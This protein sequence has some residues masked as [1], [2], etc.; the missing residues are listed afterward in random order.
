MRPAKIVSALAGILLIIPAVALMLSGGILGITYTF[1]RDTDGYVDSTIEQLETASVAI[2]APEIDL[3]ADPAGSDWLIDRLDTD[4]RLTARDSQKEVFVGIARQSDVDSYLQGVAHNEIL[5]LD[6]DLDPVYQVVPGANEVATPGSQSFWAASASGPT[7]VTVD[8]T[9]QSGRW[10][11][12]L[13][14]VD[15]SPGVLADV[16]VGATADFILPLS[17]SLI[18][19]G[20]VL[21]PLALGLIL[22]GSAGG[23]ERPTAI[24]VRHRVSGDQWGGP[25]A[26]VD[27]AHPVA[28]QANLDPSLSHW[29]W[30]VKWILAIPHFIVLALLW[31]AF[32]P[33]TAVAGIVI[34]F[35][36]KYPRSLFE[37]NVGVLRWTWRVSYYATT[38]GLGTDRYPHFRLNRQPGDLATLDI[39]YPGR[40]SRGLVLVKWW[41]LA[42]PHYIIVIILVGDVGWA[43]ADGNNIARFSLL[44][45]FAFVAGLSLLFTGIYPRAL[46]DLIVG[47]NRWIYRVAAYAALMTDTYPPFRLD[48]GGTEPARGLTGNSSGPVEPTI[49]AVP[50]SK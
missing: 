44:G 3:M 21:T 26:L 45:I 35:T 12:V 23:N 1:G 25:P 11:V 32:V 9:L 18:A 16:N 50:V 49:E 48:Q 29:K 10:A 37:F 41:L 38:G 30:L 17:I 8:W 5:D 13:M 43:N 24:D 34:L 22:F 20:A 27:E 39:A 46:F 40:L 31:I 47:L 36:G 33:L 6:D 19:L 15:G 14:N 4:V 2:V 42:I 28:L 7:P